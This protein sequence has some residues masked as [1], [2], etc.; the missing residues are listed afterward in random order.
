MNI[1]RFIH[2]FLA[3]V[4]ILA[5]LV[6]DARVYAQGVIQLPAPGTRL[7]LSPVFAPPL[8]KGIKVYRNDPF[9]FDFI[10]DKGDAKATDEQVKTDSTRLIKYFLASLTVPEKDLW[11]NLSPYEKDRIVPDVFGQMEMGRDLLAQDYILKQI[12]ASVIYPDD[13]VGKE[14]WD[15]IYAEALKRYGTTDIPVDTFNKVWIV[16]QKATVYEN[17]EAAYVVESRLKVMLESDYVAMSHQKDMSEPSAPAED[18]AMSRADTRSAPTTQ[19]SDQ[20]RVGEDFMSSRHEIA[21]DILREIIIPILEKEV[22]E[23]K[24]F[25]T[26]RQVY[27]SLILATWYKRKLKASIMG[28][29]YVDKQKTGGIDIADKNEN[30]KIWAQ[31]VEAFKKGAYNLIKEEIDP[32][33]QTVVPRKFFSGGVVLHIEHAEFVTADSSMLPEETSRN[34]VVV[35][36]DMRV[37]GS[38]DESNKLNEAFERLMKAK[39][40]PVEQQEQYYRTILSDW[41]DF[42]VGFIVTA[43]DVWAE[44][45]WALDLRELN[46]IK[47]IYY[48]TRGDKERFVKI[49]REESI[50]FGGYSGIV[51]PGNVVLKQN[52]KVSEWERS[53]KARDVHWGDTPSL[54]NNHVKE[55][56]ARWLAELRDQNKVG[57]LVLDLGG[58]HF[59]PVG[60]AL[61]KPEN[62]VVVL[63]IDLA[64]D[65]RI[66][67]GKY[68][69]FLFQGDM[70]QLDASLHQKAVTQV[71]ANG[72]GSR[73]VSFDTILLTDVLNYVDYKKVI[74]DALRYL[75]SGGRIIIINDVN[76]TIGK[77]SLSQKGV[78][79]N[80]EL[81]KFLSQKANIQIEEYH[82]I[83]ENFLRVTGEES[84]REVLLI[85]KV[86]TLS[87]TEELKGKGDI[88]P[89]A[90]IFVADASN[91]AQS[92]R[93]GIDLNPSKIDM[94]TK[95]NGD[96]IKYNLDPAMLQ[97]LQNASG[98]TPVIVGISS[99]DSVQQFLGIHQ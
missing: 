16:P 99:L 84:E 68:K 9:R 49:M 66:P 86:G 50:P 51:A 45:K 39:N 69:T 58:G 21:K 43:L 10:L 65:P 37:V 83:N 88:I 32:I 64:P 25:A 24:N 70:E 5:F 79:E 94:V 74:R 91:S 71:I 76:R 40:C 15:K 67:L 17:K 75:K 54:Y 56:F 28:Q 47:G 53:R 48:R 2:K 92:V 26:L 72:F 78:Q 59:V 96:A 6:S 29:A 18:V 85:R 7:A 8:L 34:R 63:A 22:N 98:V 82:P 3:S 23:G 13:K 30:E 90:R 62:A 93:G 12:T 60:S 89:D 73:P 1:R 52:S 19:G 42:S 38:V 33:T 35:S 87:A 4:L 44:M 11:V 27:N 77:D 36:M 20:L 97:H 31:Y 41:K 80:G 81:F 61:D 46:R 14:F 95:T 57:D 55:A